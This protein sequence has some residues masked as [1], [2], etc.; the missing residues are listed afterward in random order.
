[1]PIRLIGAVTLLCLASCLLGAQELQL[2]GPSTQG[3]IVGQK[4]VLPL[5]VTGGVQPYTWHWVSGN[6]PP[7]C[8][9]HK[10]AGKIEGVPTT[11]GDYR[12]T[13]SVTDSNIPSAQIQ[14]ELTIHVIAG[15]TI[16]WKEP[17]K[18][19]G[20][21]ISGSAVVSNQTGQDMDLTVV[22]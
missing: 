3:A 22:V 6:M 18:V 19:S 2:Q 20:N 1:M 14:R 21:A 12:F 8:Q 17:P 16:D 5:T 9:L 13:F 15:L 11:P 7:G 4:L 10:H